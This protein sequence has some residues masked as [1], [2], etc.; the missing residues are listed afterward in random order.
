MHIVPGQFAEY[1]RRLRIF[2]QYCECLVGDAFAGQAV[3][4]RIVGLAEMP[5]PLPSV[6]A[7]S[8]PKINLSWCR[9][10]NPAV[11]SGSRERALLPEFA[12]K[13][14]NRFG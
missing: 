13:S 4:G 7:Q 8:L 6:H 3:G 1:G 11:N 5:P 9:F 2:L 10:K 14:P 12:D